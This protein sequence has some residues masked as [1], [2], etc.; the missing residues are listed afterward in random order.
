MSG[1]C[2]SADAVN[3]AAVGPR[4]LVLTAPLAGL[5]IKPGAGMYSISGF[6]TYYFGSA[7]AV[8]DTTVRLGNSNLADAATPFDNNGTGTT[9]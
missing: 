8:P 2:T 5:G 6:S 1:T 4:T 7:T 9:G 3:L